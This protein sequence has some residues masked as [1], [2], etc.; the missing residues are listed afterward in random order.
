MFVFFKWPLVKPHSTHTTKTLHL[1][2][3][4]AANTAPIL[5]I[6]TGHNTGY[7]VLQNKLLPCFVWCVM[8]AP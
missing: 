3:H 7:C 4:P 2:P 6:P 8:K 1:A 5:A